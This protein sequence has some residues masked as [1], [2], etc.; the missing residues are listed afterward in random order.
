MFVERHVL[1]VKRCSR[2]DLP[3]IRWEAVR[4]V[5]SSLDFLNIQEKHRVCDLYGNASGANLLR[6][7]ELLAPC[8]VCPHSTYLVAGAL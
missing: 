6:F 2:P 8:P 3:S 1:G 7:S 5:F 4:S